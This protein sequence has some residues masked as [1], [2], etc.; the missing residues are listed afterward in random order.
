MNRAL[1]RPDT[2]TLGAQWIFEN[3]PKDASFVNQGILVAP[4]LDL[5]PD[6]DG[7][8][9]ERPIIH[10]GSSEAMGARAAWLDQFEAQGVCW[11]TV[12]GL[13]EERV[14]RDA[15]LVPRTAAYY[16]ELEK[17]GE[18]VF[19]ASPYREGAEPV[20]FNFDWSTNLYPFAFERPGGVVTIYRL[21]EGECA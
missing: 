6:V 11:V 20:P 21:D 1:G 7:V 8:Q 5:D 13:Y 19:R 14:I 2:R 17:R 16:R 10:Q 9:N 4:F 12:S 18:V 3:V 15:R